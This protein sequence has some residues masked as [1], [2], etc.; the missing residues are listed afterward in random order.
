MSK[1]MSIREVALRLGVTENRVYQLAREGV[2]P[3]VRVGR[4]V[5]VD[6]AMLEVWINGGGHKLPNGWRR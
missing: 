1:L 3:V 4:Q 5:R 6:P 2:F